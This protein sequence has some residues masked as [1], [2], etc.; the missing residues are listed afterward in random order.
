MRRADRLFQIIQVLRRSRQPVTADKLA[1]ELRVS[2]RSIYRDIADL[3][4]QGVPVRGEAG[5]GYILDREYDMPPLMLTP[6]ELEAAA[7]G[8][9]WVAERGDPALAGAAR[10]LISKI[11]SAIPQRLRPSSSSPPSG[12]LRT[13]FRL[14][15]GWIFE[16]HA[17]G[18]ATGVSF[19]SAI[20]AIRGMKHSES[21]GR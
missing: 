20:A 21:S 13:T 7:L 9:Q 19:G 11:A 10:D 14:L 16:E 6:D 15:M 4:G 5:M 17:P 12:L 3:T 8:T 18:F 1:C 2:K